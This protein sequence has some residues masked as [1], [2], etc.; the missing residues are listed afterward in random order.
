M[1]FYSHPFTKE[2]LGKT[3]VVT[4]FLLFPVRIG[5]ETRVFEE[6]TIKQVLAEKD[7]LHLGIHGGSYRTTKIVWKNVE[8]LEKFTL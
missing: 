8:F 1:K 5:N 7:T 6:A 4:K 3:R 2:D